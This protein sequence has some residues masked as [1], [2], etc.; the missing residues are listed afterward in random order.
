MQAFADVHQS[1][2]ALDLTDLPFWDLHAAL[3]PAMN[4]GAWGLDEGAEATKR[5]S[6]ARFVADAFD[7]LPAGT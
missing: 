3:G 5:A 6:L 4:M 2:S 7:S 1:L